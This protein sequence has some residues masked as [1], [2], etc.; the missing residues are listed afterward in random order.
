MMGVAPAVMES[1]RAELS[2]FLTFG[3][4]NSA[5]GDKTLAALIVLWS[6]LFGAEGYDFFLPESAFVDSDSS[7]SFRSAV[8]DSACELDLDSLSGA[9]LAGVP[10]DDV[11]AGR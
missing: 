11:L 7:S 9:V 4:A 6:Q 1:H 10:V 3:K 5:L 8:L 2:S